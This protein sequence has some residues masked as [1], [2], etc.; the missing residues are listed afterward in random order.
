MPTPSARAPRVLKARGPRW[1]GGAAS[2]SLLLRDRADLLLGVPKVPQDLGGVLAAQR[3]VSPR[4]RRRAIQVE[5]GLDQ[6]YRPRARMCDLLDEAERAHLLVRE[7]L[8]DRVDGPARG[9]CRV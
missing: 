5:G 3:R 6:P 4:A 1:E 8:G 9:A 7:D 2:G